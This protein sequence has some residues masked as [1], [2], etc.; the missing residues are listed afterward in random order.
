VGKRGGV[1]GVN[2]IL[3]SGSAEKANI[4]HYVDHIEHF[5]SLAGI[6]AVGIGFDFCEYLFNQLPKNIVEELAAKLTR[7]HF[8]PDLTN[9]THARNLTQKLIERGFADADIEK[10]LFRNWMRIFQELL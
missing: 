5:V 2:A 4:D 1:I 10:I 6:D 8:I 9:H 3:V 7:P